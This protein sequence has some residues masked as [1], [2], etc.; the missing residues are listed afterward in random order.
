M[1]CSREP[2]ERR[3]PP[4]NT[5]VI[6]L[7]QFS[8]SVPGDDLGNEL[9]GCRVNV[10]QQGAVV[11]STGQGIPVDFDEAGSGRGGRGKVV[12]GGRGSRVRP[13]LPFPLPHCSVSVAVGAPPQEEMGETLCTGLGPGRPR[14]E[15]GRGRRRGRCR[16]GQRGSGVRERRGR[17]RGGLV[18]GGSVRAGG[19]PRNNRRR[20]E[21]E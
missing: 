14:P 15:K 19:G 18:E 3:F 12:V 13:H 21:G 5:C 11:G 6:H 1:K 9:P 8:L 17:G 7:L 10:C 16:G 20:G 2:S 4:F